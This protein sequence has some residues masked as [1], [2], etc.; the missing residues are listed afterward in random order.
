MSD[1]TVEGFSN[2][3]T[4]SVAVTT[5]NESRSAQDHVRWKS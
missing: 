1:E 3:E 4:F 2:Y 5:D